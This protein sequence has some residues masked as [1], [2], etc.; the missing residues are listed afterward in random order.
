MSFERIG[1]VW[2]HLLQNSFHKFYIKWIFHGETIHNPLNE[3]PQVEENV[4]EVRDIL[5]DVMEP[6]D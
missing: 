1:V 4:D 3:E 5:N 2:V 6:D